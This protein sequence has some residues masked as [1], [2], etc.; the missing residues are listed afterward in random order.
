[1]SALERIAEL[2]TAQTRKA[3]DIT[4]YVVGCAQCF[5]PWP[6]PTRRLCDEGGAERDKIAHY[7][8]GV[9]EGI[10]AARDAACADADRL[11][12]AVNFAIAHSAGMYPGAL[13]YLRQAS[14]AHDAT[15]A[16]E[17]PNGFAIEDLCDA[18]D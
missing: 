6:C 4:P 12:A 3:V 17:G 15:R 5:K 9:I 14:A 2:H 18:D 13:D 7:L 11:A 1:M 10:E 8:A 16:K